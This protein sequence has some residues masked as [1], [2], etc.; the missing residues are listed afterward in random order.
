MEFTFL[1][2]SYYFLGLRLSFP[3]LLFLLSAVVALG[4]LVATRE[5]WRRGDA[6]Y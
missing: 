2:L 6:I 4:L 1:F 5:S 3:L